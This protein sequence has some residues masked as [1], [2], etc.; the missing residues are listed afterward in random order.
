VRQPSR[1]AHYLFRNVNDQSQASAAAGKDATGADCLKNPGLTKLLAQHLKELARAGFKDF[2]QAPLR[3][4]ARWPVASG[5]YLKLI[6]V[7]NAGDYRASI[8]PLD[9]VGF[10]Q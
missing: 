7:R 3:N 1:T 5:G 2:R 6:H 10:S 9:L 8:Q 4:Q